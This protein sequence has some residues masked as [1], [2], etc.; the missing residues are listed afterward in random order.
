MSFASLDH[1][2][3][4]PPPLLF[5][6][7]LPR[8]VFGKGGI[9]LYRGLRCRI[10]ISALSA[11]LQDTAH[12]FDVYLT[13]FSC[14]SA[15]YEQLLVI[16]VLECSVRGRRYGVPW[17]YIIHEDIWCVVYLLCVV[18]RG[19]INHCLF[20]NGIGTGILCVLSR[21]T[22]APTTFC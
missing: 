11:T 4:C 9:H 18:P 10:D 12:T 19:V 22:V 15:T 6:L 13:L 14:I 8:I 3:S 17:W 20:G 1:K 7:V 21:P 5:F 2:V 16:N